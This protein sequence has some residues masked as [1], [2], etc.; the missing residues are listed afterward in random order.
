[1]LLTQGK[2]LQILF[3]SMSVL[4]LQEPTVAQ[5]AC[6]LVESLTVVLQVA[7]SLF[8]TGF[9]PACHQALHFFLMHTTS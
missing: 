8:Q 3:Y 7:D 1:M 2:Y 9:G 5:S 6:I 4:I